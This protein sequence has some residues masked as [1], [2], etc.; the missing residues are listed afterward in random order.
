MKNV[1]S[2]LPILLLIVCGTQ[3][4]AQSF[5]RGTFLVGMSE[6]STSAYMV[7]DHKGQKQQGNRTVACR[8]GERDPLSLE[9]GI[10]DKLG[11]GVTMGTDIFQVDPE[12]F[13]GFSLPS[14]RN[15]TLYTSELTFDLNY[16]IYSNNK[17]DFSAF[18]SMGT[19][20]TCFKGKENLSSVNEL[21]GQSE[22]T[23][24]YQ[25]RGQI[26]RTGTK[27]KFYFTRRVGALG[28]FSIYHG[29]S[30]S[31]GIK[32]NTVAKNYRTNLS[33]VATEFGLC[34]RFF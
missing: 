15:I 12:K 2:Q 28:M 23:Y 17:A 5:K 27:A 33:G 24:Q 16:H 9:F 11:I 19:F 18:V 32:G 21:T 26:F 14:G 13:Y 4:S 3:V 29:E 30:S 25:S 8:K 20:S 34:F 6:G 10:S 22:W 31:G 1:F 7:T